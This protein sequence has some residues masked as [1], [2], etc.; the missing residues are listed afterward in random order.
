[1]KCFQEPAMRPTFLLYALL[2]SL[3]LGAA[4]LP[5][6]QIWDCED[7][8][9]LAQLE[10]SRDLHQAGTSSVRWR[11]HPEHPGFRLDDLPHD[12][13][14]YHLIRFWLHNATAGKARCM[15]LVHSENDATEGADY[16]QFPIQLNFSGWRQFTFAIGGKEGQAREPRGWNQIDGISFTADGWGCTPQPETDLHLDDFRLVCDPPRPGPLMSDEEFFAELDLDRPELAAVRQA[17]LANDLPAAK[18][19]LLAHFRNRRSPVWHFDWRDRP[20]DMPRLKPGSGSWDYYNTGFTV[21]WTGWKE[22]AFPFA[23]WN[24]SRTPQGWH[25]INRFRLSSTWGSRSPNPDTYLV[26]DDML[27]G[28]DTPLPIGDFETEA[29]FARWPAFAPA[30]QPGVSGTAGGA[31]R[32]ATSPEAP[33]SGLPKDWRP[34]RELRFRVYSAK[35][36]GDRITL[37]ADSDVRHLARADRVLEHV[38]NG[39][40]LGERINWE[41]NNNKPGDPAFTDEWTYSLNRF[42]QWRD[43]GEAY[44]QTGDEKYARGWI[45]QMRAWVE[46]NP[47]PRFADGNR[48]LTWRT[49]EAGI[50][51]ST[52]WPDSLMYFLGSPSLEPDDLVVFLKSWIEHA[53]HLMRITLENPEHG[54]NWVTMECNGLGHIGILLPECRQAPLWLQ[55][56]AERLGRELDRQVYPDGAQKELTTHYHQVALLNFV[57]LYQFAARNGQPLGERYLANLE[58]MYEYNLKAMDPEG[59][60]PPLNDAGRTDV[61]PS[62]QEGY[63]LFGRED[64]LWAASRGGKGIAPAYTSLALPWAGQYIMRSGWE[65]DALYCLF[66]AGPYGTGHQHEDKL[67]L[68]LHAMGRELL[69]EAGTYRYDASTYRRYA[70]GSWAHNTILVDGQGQCRRGLPEAYETTRPLDNLWLHNESFDA[71]AGVYDCGYGPRR[72]IPVRHERTVVFLRNDYWLV[73]DRLEGEGEHGLD[74]LWNLKATAAE[75]RDGG[76]AA[77]GTDPGVPNLLVTPAPVPGLELDIVT[78]R[79]VPPL[80]FA[81]VASKTPIPVLDYRMHTKLPVTLAWALTPYRGEPPQISVS[82]R[83]VP[84]GTVLTVTRPKGTDEVFVARRGQTGTA[85]LAGQ[86]LTGRIAVSRQTP[87]GT[88]R[89]HAE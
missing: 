41:S 68:V 23:E 77:H 2:A 61:R 52:T 9:G 29:D 85:V 65:P 46:D 43:L 58:R 31:W 47:Y 8:K 32:P 66:E 6:L 74:I 28:G 73:L 20:A 18:A 80:G 63:D 59:F 88:L 14:G 76:L 16:W 84:D 49:I 62:L 78:G 34:Y 26:F 48:T 25:F 72:E 4:P 1:M 86:E 83:E 7:T 64:F 56:A 70:I 10:L 42:F 75:R 50:R 12:W 39:Y 71:A 67:S 30:H 82:V 13:S 37:L 54:G 19:A 44:W 51:T 35:A 55:T 36:T 21:D 24:V 11:N 5:D 69:T 22:F 40:F 81:P 89:Q 38:F 15:L 79:Q 45:D 33:A 3:T 87:G 53:H 27:L 17:V 60:L 57:A